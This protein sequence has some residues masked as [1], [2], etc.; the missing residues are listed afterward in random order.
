MSAASHAPTPLFLSTRGTSLTLNPNNNHLT[1]ASRAGN[2]VQ[3]FFAEATAGA[4]SFALREPLAA[5]AAAGAC[6]VGA[7][8]LVASAA[9][10]AIIGSRLARGNELSGPSLLLSNLFGVS[11]AAYRD[12]VGSTSLAASSLDAELQSVRSLTQDKEEQLERIE[13]VFEARIAD[14]ER[15]GRALLARLAESEDA[16]AE[17]REAEAAESRRRETEL[18]SHAEDLQGRVRELQDILANERSQWQDAEA[19]LL[20]QNESLAVAAEELERLKVAAEVELKSLRGEVK[21]LV[22][23]MTAQK[24]EMDEIRGVLQQAMKTRDKAV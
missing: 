15:D 9:T 22:Q 18:L 4:Q 12:V 7:T 2:P 16:A 8:L 21:A 19:S 11:A 24:K 13:Q 14:L 20:R 6:T 17:L 5:G 3:T 10:R 23:S 1:I